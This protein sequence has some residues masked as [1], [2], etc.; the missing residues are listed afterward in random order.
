M[1][2]AVAQYDMP[3]T[4][5]RAPPQFL[6]I[7]R[8][9]WRMTGGGAAP[10]QQQPPPNADTQKFLEMTDKLLT[11]LGSMQTMKPNGIDVTK[12]TQAAADSIK[13]A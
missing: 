5:R 1:P 4:S 9:A 3:K 11:V 13:K 7:R 8:Q 12:Y 2:A 10:A 6:T